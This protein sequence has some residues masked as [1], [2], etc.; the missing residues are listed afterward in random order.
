MMYVKDA[1][2]HDCPF[3]NRTNHPMSGKGG[4]YMYKT[5]RYLTLI[6][7]IAFICIQLSFRISVSLKLD[8]NDKINLQ[9]N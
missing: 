5:T 1:A 3:E 4:G 8:L 7:L 6:V 9:I 2:S